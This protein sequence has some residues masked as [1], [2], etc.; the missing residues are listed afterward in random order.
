MPASV[1]RA[2]VRTPG[3]R[4]P[5]RPVRCL[6][7]RS[8][9][10]RS[11]VAARSSGPP[12]P[13][14]GGRRRPDVRAGGVRARSRYRCAC[15]SAAT[16]AGAAVP[17]RSTKPVTCSECN[18]TGQVRRV[19]QSVLGQ[20]VTSSPCQRCGGL[21]EV[22]VTPCPTCRGEGASP[23]TRRTRST[24]PLVSTPRSTLRLTGRGAAGPRSGRSGDLRPHPRG[25][26]HERYERDG[27]RPRHRRPDL[28]RPGGARHG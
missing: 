25:A 18:G 15:R 20:M 10:P 4:R 11:A 22:I 8:G 27:R 19:R 3:R 9:E 21:G 28:D 16:T 2:V 7:R 26:P 13:G 24:C 1:A 5:G 17:A 12:R 23:P 14:H 6:L